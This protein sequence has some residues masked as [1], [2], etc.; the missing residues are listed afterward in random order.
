MN[1]LVAVVRYLR[2]HTQDSTCQLSYTNTSWSC[3]PLFTLN[4]VSSG[5]SKDRVSESRGRLFSAVQLWRRRYL[6]IVVNVAWGIEGSWSPSHAS[7]SFLSFLC[8]AP[9]IQEEYAHCFWTCS[10]FLSLT[11]MERKAVIEAMMSALQLSRICHRICHSISTAGVRESLDE[12]TIA[13]MTITMERQRK[14]PIANLCLFFNLALR[15]RMMGMLTTSKTV[16][17][18]ARFEARRKP[19]QKIG[20]HVQRV[21][22][23]IKRDMNPMCRLTLY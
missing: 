17:N 15:R 16:N 20:K 23:P 22:K 21:D 6:L 1:F 11:K 10:R 12:R 14:K 5:L 8:F 19:T 2:R 7:I 4:L 9:F 18:P 13:M 3:C